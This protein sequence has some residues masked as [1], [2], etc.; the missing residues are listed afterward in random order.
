MLAGPLALSDW[1]IRSTEKL[2][3]I[4]RDDVPGVFGGD[5]REVSRVAAE[6]PHHLARAVANGVTHEIHLRRQIRR[7]VAVR[8]RVVGP[9]RARSAPSEARDELAKALGI[10]LD[11]AG[12]E[13]CLAQFLFHVAVAAGGLPCQCRLE[14][15]VREHA[16][17]AA[18]RA[19]R[20]SRDIARAEC[21]RAGRAATGG[22]RCPCR[23]GGAA[24]TG[25]VRRT[26]DSLPTA[27]RAR[28]W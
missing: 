19:C 3:G 14:D 27:S 6:I 11:E 1:Y 12:A 20:R 9:R 5:A 16:R 2:I 18:S 13:A 21:R 26:A 28:A 8:R 15:N 25:R 24:G 23:P 10:R 4:H 7:V 17:L 22:S